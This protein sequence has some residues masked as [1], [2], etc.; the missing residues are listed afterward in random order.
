MAHVTK[1]V[2]YQFKLNLNISVLI[3]LD[4][5]VFYLV[6]YVWQSIVFAAIKYS[7]L[8]FIVEIRNPVFD[9]AS[10]IDQYWQQQF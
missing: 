1:H 4:T 6:C 9:H 8:S 10:R 2:R 3:S 5:M 7:E